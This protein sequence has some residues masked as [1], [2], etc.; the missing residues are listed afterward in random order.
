[1]DEGR[2]SLFV[3]ARTTIS[4]FDE[5]GLPRIE[6]GD[7]IRATVRECTASGGRYKVVADSITNACD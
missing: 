3:D 7:R 2:T 4:G 5:F 1:M 6:E